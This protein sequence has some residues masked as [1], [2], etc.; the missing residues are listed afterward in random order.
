MPEFSMPTLQ[1]PICL[2]IQIAEVEEVKI[3]VHASCFFSPST[4]SPITTK[5]EFHNKWQ[6]LVAQA[7]SPIGKFLISIAKPRNKVVTDK[8]IEADRASG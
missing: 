7:L 4:C 1:H 3:E 2:G 8:E 5:A 6:S